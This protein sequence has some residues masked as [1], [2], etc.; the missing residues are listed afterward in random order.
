MKKTAPTLIQSAVLVDACS[1]LVTQLDAHQSGGVMF[2]CCIALVIVGVAVSLRIALLLP[3]RGKIW[4]VCKTEQQPP[5][6]PR[7]SIESS[8]PPL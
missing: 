6:E 3:S 8:K 2:V 5:A 7:H 1:N 4:K